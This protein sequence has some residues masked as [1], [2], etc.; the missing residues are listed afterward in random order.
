MNVIN[1]FATVFSDLRATRLM[2]G[3]FGKDT[4]TTEEWYSGD[5]KFRLNNNDR[6]YSGSYVSVRTNTE[7]VITSSSG[8][9]IKPMTIDI[10]VLWQSSPSTYAEDEAE[11]LARLEEA[12]R[13]K[14]NET[15]AYRIV[16]QTSVRKHMRVGSR[17]SLL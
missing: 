7:I 8:D 9:L 14:R 2:D 4:W 11:R 17:L 16:E 10:G 6:N 12:A 3:E 5:I 15:E 13:R 1:D